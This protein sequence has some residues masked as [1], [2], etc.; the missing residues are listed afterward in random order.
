[1]VVKAQS[2]KELSQTESLFQL[3]APPLPFPAESPE[4][5]SWREGPSG[6]STLPRSPRD[7]QCSASSE[8]SGPS[9]P[10]HTSSPVQGK[11]RYAEGPWLPGHLLIQA[12]T[13]GKAGG[14]RRL[15]AGALRPC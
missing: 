2:E 8:L 3:T 7:A 6:H 10:L 5:V 15:T 12:D 13:T 14:G 1:M 11:E 4:P 9:T